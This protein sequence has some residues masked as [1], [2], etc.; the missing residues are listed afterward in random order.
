[1][2]LVASSTFLSRW[3]SKFSV[4]DLLYTFDRRVSFRIIVHS[5]AKDKDVALICSLS[6]A[7][8]TNMRYKRGGFLV[9]IVTIWLFLSYLDGRGNC[10]TSFRVTH[11][12]TKSL[13]RTTN[14]PPTTHTFFSV[15]LPKT[16]FKP[17]LTMKGAAPPLAIKCKPGCFNISHKSVPLK[18][19]S[20]LSLRGGSHKKG[21]WYKK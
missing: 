15:L 8:A 5:K 7:H 10:F 20:L 17:R 13:K 21:R 3:L 12:L 4:T 19:A 1:M 6:V 18:L 16:Y 14:S 9:V 2:V 11:E